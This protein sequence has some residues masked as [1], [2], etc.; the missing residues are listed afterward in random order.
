MTPLCDILKKYAARNPA[1]FHM[2]G[3]KGGP[4]PLPELSDAARL[5]VTE[6][7]G[8]G[9][10]YLAGEPFDSAQK[11]WA[12]RFGF[13]HCQ[14]LTGGSTMGIHTGLSLLC[15]PGDQILVDRNCHRAVFNAMA[16]LDLEPV[17][18]ERPWLEQ[19]NLI[20]PVTPEQVEFSLKTHPNIKTVC[21]TSPTYAGVLSDIEAI[22]S[23]IHAHGGS[24]FVDGAH[25]AHLPFLGLSP[26][27]GA[28]GVVVSAHKT[29][30]ALGQAAL[31]FT[32]GADP[33]R[34]RR[35]ASVFGTSSPSYPILAS[36]DAARAWLEGD[37]AR[38]YRQTALRVAQLR[39]RFPSLTG[40][41]S[42][43]PARLTLNVQDGPSFAR[44]LE[45]QNIF[46]EMEDGGHV[47]FICTPQDL[48]ENFDRLERALEGME[49][50]MG[51]CPP[52][53]SPPLP[54]R[55]CSLREALFAPTQLVPLYHSA[56]RVSAAQ[57][58]P[59]PPGVPVV[60]PGER[61]SE[62]E[63][64]YFRKI[65]YN[66]TDIPVIVSSGGDF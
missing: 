40:D 49:D 15:A 1:R 7:P 8:T 17:Y 34:V 35:M 30:P 62:K 26:F 54:E 6:I 65:G 39:S 44:S 66:S 3:H 29:L 18:L 57:I 32:S 33:D 58:A 60:A 41:L 61:I 5:D 55:A 14:F 48:E 27:A 50:R 56:G 47:V 10:L 28:D 43:D 4:L 25:G 16:L 59:Y 23:V 19:E 52:L 38:A 46:P 37:G 36:M 45:E 64:A 9:N 13:D 2:P 20:G 53:P 51:P 24:L 11:P 22:S 31:L 21:I 42:L 12:E 63:L